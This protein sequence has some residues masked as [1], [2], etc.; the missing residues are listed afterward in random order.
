MIIGLFHSDVAAIRKKIA[1]EI[2]QEMLQDASC[3]SENKM[4]EIFKIHLSINSQLNL[5][6]YFTCRATFPQPKMGGGQAKPY[7]LSLLKPFM[8]IG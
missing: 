3:N 5:T 1:L 6:Y 4:C 7:L 8:V 2:L